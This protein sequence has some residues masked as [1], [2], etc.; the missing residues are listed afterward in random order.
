MSAFLVF[1][2]WHARLPTQLQTE[3]LNDFH[4]FHFTCFSA[5]QEDMAARI[6]TA[7][8]EAARMPEFD[9]GEPS[10]ARCQLRAFGCCPHTVHTKMSC[11]GQSTRQLRET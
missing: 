3:M 11:I 7:R 5:L 1:L 4:R 10:D 9:Y 2:H 8:S 6:T